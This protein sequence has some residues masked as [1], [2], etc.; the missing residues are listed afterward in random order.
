MRARAARN[1]SIE[2]LPEIVKFCKER[3][4]KTYLTL[5]IVFYDD[6]IEEMKALCDKAKEA[7]ITAVIAADFAVIEYANSIGV[8]VHISTQ[9]NVSNFSSL[10]FY[11][12]YA[13]V[14]VLARELELDKIK[15]II[16]R[17]KKENICG[18]SGELLKI[19]LFVHGALC[20]SISGKCYMSLGLYNHSANRGDCLQPCRRKYQVT[21]VETSNQLEI[22]NN[23]VMSPKDLC[24]ISF[25]DKILNVG[26]GVL[27]IEGRGRSPEY[28]YSV[29]KT[30]REAVES[31][32]SGTFIQEKV[33]VWKLE[34][35]KVFNRGF[36]EGGY[37]LGKKLGE[38][39]GISGSLATRKKEFLGDVKNYY[40]EKGVCLIQIKSGEL[41]KGEEVLIV[42]STTGLVQIKAEEIWVDEKSVDKAGKGMLVTFKV[43]EKVRENDKV[44]V[45]RK[46]KA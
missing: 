36:W 9:A 46:K 20:V 10:K 3:G 8:E 42:G 25:L 23:Y 27:K 24:T 29:V 19:E 15:D 18:P 26:V 6:E 21:D 37:Y 2:E 22:D 41:L 33:K 28:V 44:Y 1:F 11:A 32:L 17:V 4:V 45:L 14:I 7:G 35:D 12:R 31:Y 34:L 30:Y 38:W 43:F 13:D 39:S 40:S 5:N 16:A